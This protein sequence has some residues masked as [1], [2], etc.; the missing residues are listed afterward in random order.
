MAIRLEEKKAITA[1][2]KAIAADALS[3]VVANARGVTVSEI[4][5]LRQAARENAVQLRVI[6]NSLARRALADTDG[7]I[8]K[9]F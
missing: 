3:L 8:P 4:T 9:H 5:V 1:E 7:S 2:V 6:R